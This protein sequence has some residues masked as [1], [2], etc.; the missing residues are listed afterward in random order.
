[1]GVRPLP[2]LAA[3]VWNITSFIG[4]K[5]DF[6]LIIRAKGTKVI[7]ATSLV[8]S[9]ELKKVMYININEIFFELSN[10]VSKF[11]AI[12]SNIFI[13]LKALTIIIR[14][15]NENNTLKSIYSILGNEK[16]EVITARD[17]AK[18]KTTSFLNILS[19]F[20]K[21]FLR[22]IESNIIYPSLF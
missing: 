17:K 22:E 4:L 6:L 19:C 16:N 11:T 21:V 5:L 10:L 2:I 9:I 20:A 12:L 7:R 1:M 8:M 13:T 14:L 18:V 15:N 3:I